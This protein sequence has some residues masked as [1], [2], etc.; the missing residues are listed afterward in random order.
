MFDKQIFEL[1]VDD[2]ARCGVWF[3]PMDESVEDELTVRPLFEQELDSDFQIIVRTMFKGVDGSE[4]LGFVYWDGS[5]M[6][7]YT[8]PT[9]ILNDGFSI[10]FWNGLIKP[11]WL[12]CPVEVQALKEVLPI[13][14][15]S[16][17]LLGLAKI[18]GVL[19][20]L[21]YLDGELVSVL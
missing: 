1:T 7:E 4:Y 16:E 19:E 5:G 2:L 12:D 17:P 18:S 6:V 10:S 13:S 14:Y 9:I 15:V 20:G 3:F 8:K 21:Y 11:S